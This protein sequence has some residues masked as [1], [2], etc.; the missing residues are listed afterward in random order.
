MPVLRQ[1]TACAEPAALVLVRAGR[2]R[3]RAVD[4]RMAMCRRHRW[5]AERSGGRRSTPGPA[6]G[7]CG[8]VMDYR[9]YDE[10][11]RS[12]YEQWLRPM[13][14]SVI[15]D[16]GDDVAATLRA[17]H[18]WLAG[19]HVDG[20][21]RPLVP[22]AR[23]LMPL[24]GVRAALDQAA[25]A[26]EALAAGLMEEHHGQVHVLAALALAETLDALGRGA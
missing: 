2:R 22:P 24:D 6:G 12:H 21:T 20:P 1:I 15:E 8:T 14:G 3:G 18:D 9:T 13:T 7:R 5:L 25:R 23:S 16:H 19:E 11:L 17:A 26:T 10:V 4:Y